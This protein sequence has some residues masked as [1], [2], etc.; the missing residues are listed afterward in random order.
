MSVH[1]WDTA[2]EDSLVR[3]YEHHT[4][5]VLGL[6]FNVFIDGLIATTSWDQL[7]TAFNI[8]PT[9]KSL[10]PSLPLPTTAAGAGG[11]VVPAGVHL[12]DPLPIGGPVAAPVERKA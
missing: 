6:D 1:V 7:V 11:A 9:T 2:A 3:R 8:S 4:E 5:F 12:T 10:T